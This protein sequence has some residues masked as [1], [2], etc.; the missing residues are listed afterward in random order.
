MMY[1]FDFVIE[2]VGQLTQ[3]IFERLKR[4]HQAADKVPPHVF[5]GDFCQFPK[6]EPTCAKDSVSWQRVLVKEHT[7]RRCKRNILRQKVEVLR[8]CR[9][10]PQER[11]IMQRQTAPSDDARA[12][13]R[14]CVA[15]HAGDAKHNVSHSVSGRVCQAECIACLAISRSSS[16]QLIPK[17]TLT[18]TSGQRR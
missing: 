7:M 3:A 1:P 8:H 16:Y 9:P 5:V 13:D 12:F 4:P 17:T 2:E 18:T 14:W 10:T 15:H 11:W 6:M